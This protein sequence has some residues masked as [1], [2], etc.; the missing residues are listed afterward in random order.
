MVSPAKNPSSSSVAGVLSYVSVCRANSLRLAAVINRLSS[1]LL[2]HDSAGLQHPDGVEYYNLLLSLARGVDYA[3]ANNDIPDNIERMPVL[4]KQVCHRKCDAWS[5]AVVMVV[6]ISVKNAC[7]AGWFQ[8]KEKQELFSLIDNVGSCFNNP[9]DI[10]SGTSASLCAIST[11]LSRFYPWMKMGEILISLEV[12][13]GYGA[14]ASD[15]CIVKDTARSR[16]EKLRLLVARTDN[17][18]TSACIISPPSV[19]FL[20]NGS[21]VEQRT[22]DPGPQIPTNV[23]SMLTYGSNLLQ[24]IGQFNGHYVIAIA[25]MSV[26]S[27]IDTSWLKD[28][29]S[30]IISAPDSDSELIEGP[31]KI[32][33][34]CPIS[35]SRIRVPVK[36]QSC[37]HPQ[38]FD[39]GNFVG[40]NSRRPSWR[41]PHCIQSVC[42]TDLRVDPNIAKVLKEVGSAITNVMISDDGSWKA[43]MESDD[44][45]DVANKNISNFSTEA[46]ENQGCAVSPP[47]VNAFDLTGDDDDLVATISPPANIQDEDRKPPSNLK[48]TCAVNQDFVHPE[49]NLRS[50]AFEM[51]TT[52]PALD[53]QDIGGGAFK[54]TMIPNLS[55][56]AIVDSF[57]PMLN[58]QRIQ[59]LGTINSVDPMVQS[60]SL[61][62]NS[63]QLNESQLTNLIR[64]NQYPNGNRKVVPRSVSR[65]P[66]AV[67][68]LPVQQ[69]RPNLLQRPSNV[70][71]SMTQNRRSMASPV[72]LSQAQQELPRSVPTSLPSFHQTTAI[73]GHAHSPVQYVQLPLSR[74]ATPAPQQHPMQLHGC[75][76]TS[77]GLFGFTSKHLH[78]ALNSMPPTLNQSPSTLRYPLTHAQTPAAQ[79]S[80]TGAS[81]HS[82]FQIP[83]QGQNVPPQIV[84]SR[85]PGIGVHSLSEEQRRKHTTGVQVS[86]MGKRLADLASEQ[87]WRPAGR[88]RGSL[89]GR[90]FTDDIS[91]LVIQPTKS[92]QPGGH[93]SQ[94]KYPASSSL[95]T[96]PHLCSSMSNSKNTNA[97]IQRP[98]IL[99]HCQHDMR[100]FFSLSC[101]PFWIQLG[102]LTSKELLPALM[103]VPIPRRGKMREDG[104]MA[105]GRLVSI[106]L[107]GCYIT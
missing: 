11:I 87:N 9:G 91:H 53:S 28:H 49:G 67:Q 35:H 13:P 102:V 12:K 69:Q 105:S 107:L 62:A 34:N 83:S 33:L 55:S 45:F 90:P 23:T 58:N 14:Y 72:V 80:S 97:E 95:S 7:K 1:H 76:Q 19:N 15:F 2:L 41:C 43:I 88:M 4:L 103:P 20:L 52:N 65:N 94:P 54:P 100:A 47:T 57:S 5:Q 86:P 3:V 89:K 18:E 84:I 26:T 73:Q 82:T 10:N 60:Q 81:A 40:I 59:G 6:M 93:L 79:T 17:M 68:R 39:F 78:R 96:P 32:S 30:P 63:L 44:D 99:R 31:S 56:P 27:A 104:R 98:C 85:P 37:K 22:N 61:V 66:V 50:R 75:P 16:K 77:N 8:E 29:I 71:D 46:P 70:M 92:S 64:N 48:N 101:A 21:G 51:P 38:C 36:G 25:F 42:Y 106:Q 74:P 24:A